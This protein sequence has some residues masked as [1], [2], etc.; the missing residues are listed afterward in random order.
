[1]LP[2]YKVEKLAEAAIILKQA[3]QDAHDTIGMLEN[4]D[5]ITT[6]AAEAGNKATV[7]EKAATVM[8]SPVHPDAESCNVH[9]NAVIDLPDWGVVVA[10]TPAA[11]LSHAFEKLAREPC[12][13]DTEDPAEVGHVINER[14]GLGLGDGAKQLLF[15]VLSDDHLWDGKDPTHVEKMKTAGQT[16]SAGANG[17]AMCNYWN[18]LAQQCEWMSTNAHTEGRRKVKALFLDNYPRDDDR[19]D[20]L[21][22]CMSLLNIMHTAHTFDRGNDVREA[23]TVARGVLREMQQDHDMGWLHGKPHERGVSINRNEHLEGEG[24]GR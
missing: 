23:C 24:L 16:I 5:R 15:G 9:G 2:H 20:D 19:S 8:V 3:A 1:M 13:F 6:P 10:T 18:E 11:I 22:E 7:D 12:R 21:G 14:L 4:S 17:L